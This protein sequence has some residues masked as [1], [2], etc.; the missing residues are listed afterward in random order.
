MD[1]E[2]GCE[3]VWR[4]AL[5]EDNLEGEE[6]VLGEDREQRVMI[7]VRLWKERSGYPR[8]T[9]SISHRAPISSS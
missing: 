4:G 2:E 5:R 3:V 8:Q 9:A 6:G 7:N 1:A